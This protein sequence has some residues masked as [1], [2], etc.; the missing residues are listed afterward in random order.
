MILV[1]PRGSREELVGFSSTA[2]RECLQC[3]ADEFFSRSLNFISHS[4]ILTLGLSS[5]TS[6]CSR[7]FISYTYTIQFTKLPILKSTITSTENLVIK[8]H[9]TVTNFGVLEDSCIFLTTGNLQ[10]I[11]ICYDL[12]LR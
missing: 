11:E 5:F 1:L 7:Y 3:L 4:L 12:H 9:N 10:N 2:P 8:W 6:K